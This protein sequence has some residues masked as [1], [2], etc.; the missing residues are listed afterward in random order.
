VDGCQGDAARAAAIAWPLV[1]CRP[2]RPDE[3]ER[4]LLFLQD[5]EAE[6]ART[7]PPAS[8]L[9]TGIPPDAPMPPARGAAW[10]EWCIALLNA[11]EFVYVD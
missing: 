10:V 2:I 1:F 5:R 6:W 11:N 3:S 9:P 7:E 4:A 8:A